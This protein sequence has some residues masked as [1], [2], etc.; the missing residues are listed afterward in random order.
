M[1][2]DFIADRLIA[3]AE[4]RSLILNKFLSAVNK[5]VL[6]TKQI[7]QDQIEGVFQP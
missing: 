7:V 1:N 4:L 5:F 3:V 6:N 2:K